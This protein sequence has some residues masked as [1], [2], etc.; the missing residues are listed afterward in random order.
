MSDIRL[1]PPRDEATWYPAPDGG[2]MHF[3]VQHRVTETRT[4]ANPH[5]AV[6]T[7]W[8]SACGKNDTASGWG[9]D[10]RTKGRYYLLRKAACKE[11]WT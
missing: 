5:N 9:G 10:L 7:D 4:W 3:G 2:V 8:R 11:C 1:A 6:F